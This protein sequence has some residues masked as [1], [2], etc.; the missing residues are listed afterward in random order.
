MRKRC[1]SKTTD[2]P[3]NSA[4]EP[5]PLP[6][7]S[8]SSYGVSFPIHYPPS[9]SP[10][11]SSSPSSQNR[12]TSVYPSASPS[13]PHADTQRREAAKATTTLLKPST[14]TSEP[15][16]E[17]MM[18]VVHGRRTAP[19]PTSFPFQPRPHPEHCATTS[20]RASSRDYATPCYHP[21]STGMLPPVQ[22]GTC[23]RRCIRRR[24]RGMSARRD[25]WWYLSYRSSFVMDSCR[26]NNRRLRYG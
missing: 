9:A 6:D 16:L 26:C 5:L 10:P 4:R 12:Q 21:P 2:V 1:I 22:S 3:V 7:P 15:T 25:P 20:P 14:D 23:T 8:P 24:V 19:A 17:T 13:V 18:F 11:R